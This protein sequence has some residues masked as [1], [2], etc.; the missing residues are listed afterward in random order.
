M[1]AGRKRTR[2]RSTPHRRRKQFDRPTALHVGFHTVGGVCNLRKQRPFNVVK[3][4]LQRSAKRF[5]TRIIHFAVLSNHV[6]LIVESYDTRSLSRA[7][8]GLCVCLAKRLNQLMGRH[9]QVIE[10]RHFT[11]IIHSH[12][13]AAKV[14]RYVREN[15]RKHTGPPGA[16]KTGVTIDP[17]SSWAH[18]ILLLGPITK[19]LRSADPFS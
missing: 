16:W 17:R 14:M 4:A 19:L 9:G 12:R 10:D 8:K 5:R 6:H 1:G 15:H 11:R 3:H 18:V 2:A 13:A 7:M